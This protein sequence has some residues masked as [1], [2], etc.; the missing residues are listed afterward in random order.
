MAARPLTPAQIDALPQELPQWTLREG[1]LHRELRFA[2]FSAAFGF[3]ARVALA[4]EAM[5]H[6]PEWCNVWNRVTI[7]LTTHDTGGLSD[8]DV[9]LARRIDAL[10]NTTIC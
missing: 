1:K 3:M 10:V 5:G 8:L 2:D 7:N 4:A 9:A 6:H